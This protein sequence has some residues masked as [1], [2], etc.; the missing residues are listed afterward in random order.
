MII[1]IHIG[2]VWARHFSSLALLAS[3]TATAPA[4]VLFNDTFS[5]GERLA[6][7]LPM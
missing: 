3:L 4:A 1:R 7:T 6:H 2:R 5:D